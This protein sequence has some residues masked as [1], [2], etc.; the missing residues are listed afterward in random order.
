MKENRMHRN[1][2]LQAREYARKN[3]SNLVIQASSFNGSAKVSVADQLE[4]YCNIPTNIASD[5]ARSVALEKQ[6]FNAP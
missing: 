1:R 2:Y 4:L 6:I 3:W 5:I